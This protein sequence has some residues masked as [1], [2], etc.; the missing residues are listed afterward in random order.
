MSGPRSE[1]CRRPQLPAPRRSLLRH[2][3]FLKLWS[4]ETISQAGTQVSLLAIPVVAVL[5][6]EA[7]PFEVALL[8]TIELLPFILFTLPAGVWVDRLRRRPILIAGDIVRAA[9]LISIP[10]AYAAG[11]LSMPQLY[12]VGFINGIA[13]VFFDVAYQSYLPALVERDQLVEGNSKLE[14]SRSAAAILGP[15]AAGFLIG[16]ITAPIAIFVDSISFL[17][18]ALFLVGIRRREPE[19]VRQVDEHGR[20]RSSMRR[21]TMEGLRYVLGHRYLRAIAA[22]T[23]VVEP[24]QP[25]RL[26]DP[27]GLPAARARTH[28]RDRRRRVL[29][30]GR[31]RSSSAPSPA[32]ASRPASGSVGRSCSQRWRSGRGTP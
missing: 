28:A 30:R 9:S 11:V 3:D 22:C 20:V 29:D 13:T 25:V 19:V 4:A 8:G 21:E 16:A 32:T 24:L 7:S 14:V 26:R 12:V 2:A 27:R 6:L 15:G 18:S 1:P 5:L 10:V 31:R 23:A 17:A